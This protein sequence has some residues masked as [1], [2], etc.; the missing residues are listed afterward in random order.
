M[1]RPDLVVLATSPFDDAA[2][3]R[4]AHLGTK[5]ELVWGANL[6]AVDH[7]LS[8]AR[9]IAG[10]V[11]A[12]VLAKAPQLEWVHSW[13]AGVETAVFPELPDRG[14]TLTSSAGNG[15]IPLAEHALMLM[16]ML[17]RDAVRWLDAQRARRWDRFTHGE[18]AGATVG[19]IGL[20]NVGVEI[21]RRARAFDMQVLAL[22]RRA[23]LQSPEVDRIFG[24]EQLHEFVASCDYL[25][26][27][28][29]A[30]EG[31]TGLIDA[32][33]LAAMKPTASI[34]VVSRGGIVDDDALLDALR[35]GV[36]RSAAL[37]AHAIEPL[38]TDSPF[39]SEPNVIITPHN[40]ATSAA[41][42]ARAVDIFV[43]NLG[44]FVRGEPL[45]NVVDLTQGY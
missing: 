40:G 18:L 16:L 38:P 10:P 25:V 33:A 31:T 13:L 29:A 32:A 23:W 14:V 26:V 21:A 35:R 34:V 37:D 42:P 9:V 20:G 12:E 3:R 39:W 6:G 17:D 30:T 11:D 45:R 4:V 43:D 7:R 44:R 19:L 41:T 22:R 2:A 1:A 27:T 28:A 36:I 8:D 5:L 24:A 15:A